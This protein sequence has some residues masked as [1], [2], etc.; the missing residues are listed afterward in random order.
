MTI[1]SPQ[2]TTIPMN[3]LFAIANLSVVSLKLDTSVK[4]LALF[5]PFTCTPHIAF[6]MDS[7][8]FTKFPS[9]HSHS[10]FSTLL[11]CYRK[12]LPLHSSCEQ[13]TSAIEETFFISQLP[14]LSKLDPPISCSDSH[15]N[16]TSST[17]THPVTKICKHSYSVHLI[18]QSYFLHY[19]LSNIRF[20]FP[21]SNILLK[22]WSPNLHSGTSIVDPLTILHKQNRASLYSQVTDL[23]LIKATSIDAILSNTSSDHYFGLPKINFQT[24]AHKSL[25]HLT[26]F[27]SPS[28]ASLVKVK[29]SAYSN[30]LNI[31]P[32]PIQ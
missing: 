4:S 11:H 5:L 27:L 31:P 7:L 21:A 17:C 28:I 32:S 15:G 18:T 2:H 6:T 22:H 25:C 12:L 8:S 29:S 20:T 24:L 1:L 9:Q 19:C 10:H 3:T 16:L 14:T 13:P 23:T 26:L 30:S